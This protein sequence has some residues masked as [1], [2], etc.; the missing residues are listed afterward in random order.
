MF[1]HCLEFVSQGE[2]FVCDTALVHFSEPAEEEVALFF[3]HNS[4]SN[5]LNKARTCGL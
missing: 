1:L 2:L 3:S 5:I 4:E